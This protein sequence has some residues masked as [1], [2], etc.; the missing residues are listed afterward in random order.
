MTGFGIGFGLGFYRP[1]GS[2]ANPLA[3][4]NTVAPVASG[5]PTVGQVLSVTNGT[6]TN[7]PLSYTYQWYRSGVYIAGATSS[8]YT[9]VTADIGATM[10]CIVAATNASGSNPAVSN[11]LGPVVGNPVGSP[12]G[13]LL[14]LTKAS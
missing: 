14:I 10:Y 6:W 7:T 5:T 11:S 4:A 1:D 8:T 13:L 2:A 3:P 9:L 12:I